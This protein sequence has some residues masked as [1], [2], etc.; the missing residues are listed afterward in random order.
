M[1]LFEKASRAKF[2]YPFKG[3]VSTEDLWDMSVEELDSVYKTLNKQVKVANEESLLSVKKSEDE[4]L[5]SQIE[6]VKHIVTIKLAEAE[7]RKNA[8]AKSEQK[9]KLFAI[10]AQKQDAEL[11][12]KTTAEI[13]AMI[14]AL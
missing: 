13:Q 8:K 2:R 6:I 11:Q 14:D 5:A 4:T 9:Q 7:D 3:S 10:L 1:E 12:G